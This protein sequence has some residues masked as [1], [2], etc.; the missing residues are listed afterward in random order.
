MV[1]S[2]N[3]ACCRGP[4]AA[5]AAC[6]ARVKEN[7]ETSLDMVDGKEK[8]M[9]SRIDHVHKIFGHTATFIRAKAKLPVKHLERGFQQVQS[10]LLTASSVLWI[11]SGVYRFAV[12]PKGTWRKDYR[13]VPA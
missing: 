8:H 1:A 12:Y 9:C 10:V 11:T 2:A 13:A 6:E 5:V 7:D 3:L 4:P